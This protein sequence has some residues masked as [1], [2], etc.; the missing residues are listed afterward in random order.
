M[1]RLKRTLYRLCQSPCVFWKYLTKAVVAAGM[2]VSKLDPCLF[3][4]KRVTAVAFVDD[5]L[6]WVTDDAYI[7]ELANKLWEQGVLLE[8]EGDTACFLG[9]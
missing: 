2:E 7:N 8:Q 6:F 3:V 4:G 5:I 1:L 9:V